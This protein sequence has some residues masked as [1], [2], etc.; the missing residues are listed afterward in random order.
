VE[1]ERTVSL[2]QQKTALFS[3]TRQ[4]QCIF[5]IA[6]SQLAFSAASCQ[7][8]AVLYNVAINAKNAKSWIIVFV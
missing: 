2:S 5:F 3:F 8:T 1:Q 4:T 7:I 6:W